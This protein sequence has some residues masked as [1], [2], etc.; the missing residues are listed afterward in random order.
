[1]LTLAQLN[2]LD[3]DAFVAAVGWVFENSPWLAERAWQRRPFG[4]LDALH[5][6]MMEELEAAT[7]EEKL[8]L[9]REHPDLGAR[10]RMT[11]ASAAEQAGAGLESLAPQEFARL[12]TMNAAYR[13][14]FRFPFL[15]AVRGSTTRDIL[16][17]LEA[18]LWAAPEEEF[19][20]ALQEVSR[21]ARFRLEDSVL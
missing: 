19:L 2:T 5:A 15:Y 7:L 20:I 17:A 14:K 6:A 4:S 13:E 9:L 3:R 12:Q 10:A 1:V 16:R 11:D 21:I 18:R 8:A